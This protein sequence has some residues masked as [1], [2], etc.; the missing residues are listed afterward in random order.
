MLDDV[1]D[2]IAAG[3]LD[4]PQPNAAD[5]QIATGG[6]CSCGSTIW[7]KGSSAGRPDLTPDA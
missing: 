3:I 5:Y 6:G 1:D 7:G 2:L 4:G